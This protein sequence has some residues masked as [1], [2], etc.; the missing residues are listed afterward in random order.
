MFLELPTYGF[1]VRIQ[2]E[3]EPKA[4]GKVLV[5]ILLQMITHMTIS[6][7]LS[8]ALTAEYWVEAG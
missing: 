3:D 6:I 8:F 1:S 5:Q 7:C 2:A 4:K